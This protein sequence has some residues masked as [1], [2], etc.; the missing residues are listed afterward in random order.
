MAQPSETLTQR[1]LG[2]LAQL[3][4]PHNG[5]DVALAFLPS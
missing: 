5:Q 4:E 3:I 1:G 2:L